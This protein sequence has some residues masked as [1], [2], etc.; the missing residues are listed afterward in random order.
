MGR[1]QERPHRL[2]CPERNLWEVVRVRLGFL[3]RLHIGADAADSYRIALDLFAPGR[4]A[5]LRQRLGR[6]APLPERRGP[7]ALGLPVPGRRRRAH[8]T[9][10]SRHRHRHPAARRPAARRRG[11]RRGGHYERRPA[12][13]WARDRRRSAQLRRLRQRSC[14]ARRE[15]YAEGSRSSE[16]PGRQPVNG[17]DARLYPPAPALQSGSGNRRSAP[18]AAPGSEQNGNGLLLARTA[19]S[20]PGSRRRR[21]VPV[22]GTPTS[23]EM[24]ARGGPR[25]WACP[26]P[27]TPPTT[28]STAV[29]HL[30][31]GISAWVKEL[32][33]RGLFPE[34]ADPGA[35]LRAHPRPLRPARRGRRQPERRPPAPDDVRADRQV[36]PGVP[37]AA[38]IIKALERIAPQVAPALGWQPN[39]APS[40]PLPRKGDDV[41]EADSRAAQRSREGA[42]PL[43]AQHTAAHPRREPMTTTTTTDDIIST[44]AGGAPAP[45]AELRAQRPEAMEHAQGSYTALFDPAER[46]GSH[47]SSDSPS[48][49]ESRDSRRH[50]GR[51]PLPSAPGGSRCQPL[52]RR[53]SRPRRRRGRQPARPRG[54]AAHS[55]DPASRRPALH[56]PRGRLARRPPGARRRRPRHRRD[57]GAVADRG[58]RQLPG[59]SRGGA[60]VKSPAGCRSSSRRPAHPPT[61]ATHRRR[62]RSRER[63]PAG[64]H[65]SA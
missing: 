3:T 15:R 47:P 42:S 60:P 52:D 24:A 38:Q 18:R 20:R 46:V 51:R 29:A 22:S 12:P 39:V 48:R 28:T 32:I 34:G 55:G 30:D 61:S 23:R 2:P 13:A 37:T 45:A 8:Q 21:P 44:L 27:S 36:H 49:C 63:A 58:V 11:R 40:S 41:G 54:T 25:G 1:D 10:R 59:S 50:R 64:H 33:G 14:Q 57:R 62:P 6:P 5:W 56:P 7:A 4:G 35:V 16:R 31:P 19:A 9:D 43:A 26:A 65:R 53:G 17:T